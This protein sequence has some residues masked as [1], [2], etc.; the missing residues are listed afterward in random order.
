ML[1]V[2]AAAQSRQ[3]AMILCKLYFFML[4]PS[5]L[6]KFTAFAI[7]GDLGFTEEIIFFRSFG[8]EFHVFIA[9][10]GSPL[11]LTVL[12]VAFHF[13]FT[14]AVFFTSSLCGDIQR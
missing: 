4:M 9:E 1:P 8:E 7:D 12:V 14:A 5:L 2:T 11:E 6:V 13:I 3:P 10:I